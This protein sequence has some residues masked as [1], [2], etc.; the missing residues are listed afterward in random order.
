MSHIVP[1]I[2]ASATGDLLVSNVVCTTHNHSK[3]LPIYYS[4]CLAILIIDECV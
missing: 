3:S 4:I 2:A 1:V